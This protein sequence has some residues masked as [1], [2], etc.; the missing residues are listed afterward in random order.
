MSE[1][2]ARGHGIVSPRESRPLAGI[3]CMLGGVALLTLSD[4]AAKWFTADYPV[5]QVVSIRALFIIAFIVFFAAARNRVSDLRIRSYRNHLLR[6]GFACA[7]TLLFVMGLSL[8]PLADA[9]AVTFAGPLFITA[10]A[11]LILRERVGWRRWLA[12][13]AGF[14]G[15]LLMVRPSGDYARFAVLLPL[16]AAL[17]GSLRDLV[18]RRIS[19]GESSTAILLSTNLIVL[20][21]GLVFFPAGWRLPDPLDFLLMGLAGGLMG[22]AHYLHI[23]AFR[24]AEAAV[25][26]PFKYTNMVW[27]VLFGFVIWGHLPDRWVVGGS[28][29]VIASGLYIFYRERRVE[30]LQKALQGA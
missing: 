2:A 20:L 13:L 22:A 3:F 12:V 15:V 9:I 16:G 17:A 19:I 27:G 11:P 4:A 6:G 7:S 25:I 29:V 10:L 5:G 8:L 30:S 26:A 24:L 23:E 14:T 18:T 21:A 28:L 1:A